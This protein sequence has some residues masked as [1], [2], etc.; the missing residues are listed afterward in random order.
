MS[1]M[2]AGAIA[3]R[4]ATGRSPRG[5]AV[6]CPDSP[7]GGCETIP[8]VAVEDLRQPAAQP[9]LPLALLSMLVAG[10]MIRGR[11]LRAMLAVV[12]SW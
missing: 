9:G 2:S 11:A 1:S 6:S 10:W 3:G 12:E 8:P 7:I 5:W 4:A